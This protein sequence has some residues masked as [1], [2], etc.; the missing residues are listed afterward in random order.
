MVS[1]I[2]NS[3]DLFNTDFRQPFIFH[4]ETT[5][6][7]S[8]HIGQMGVFPNRQ[9]FLHFYLCHKSHMVS[10]FHFQVKENQNIQDVI[11]FGVITGSLSGP[12]HFF[13]GTD[14]PYQLLHILPG[15]CWVHCQLSRAAIYHR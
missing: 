12:S 2:F 1:D 4:K 8:K 10:S 5:I 6:L 14:R 7:A 13:P 15:P 9:F 11:L 3:S